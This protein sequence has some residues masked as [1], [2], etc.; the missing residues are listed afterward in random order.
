MPYK[1]PSPISPQP[2]VRCREISTADVEEVVNLL[3]R[4]FRTGRDFW[5]GAL[6]RLSDHPTP[7]GL[8]R[9][10]YL[11]ESKSIPVGVIL[12]IST[13]VPGDG[14]T[15]IQCN[16]SSWYVDPEFRVYGTVLIS[17]ALKHK[18]VTYFNVTPAPHTLPILEAQG[19]VRYC[20][21]RVVAVPALCG[22][23][24]DGGARVEAVTPAT[25]PGEDLPSSEIKLLLAHAEYGCLSLVCD[26]ASRRHP[27]V[28]A[29]RRKFGVVP[30]ALLV[31]CR[32]LEEFVRFAGPLG[33]FLARR[34]ILLV[35]V[36]ANGPIP[37]L[38]GRYSN[39]NPKYFKGPNQ[40]RLGNM[41]FSERAM[42]GA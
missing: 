18:H 24:P 1:S 6:K 33:R 25:R 32:D 31:Y 40:P 10:G 4:G 37:E 15:R 38:V 19:Y 28:F 8:P 3:A 5:L 2:R 22:Q 41:A 7:S 26:S 21:G 14:E 29:L 34:G 9:Y 23:R 42:F 20:N 11:L 35:I 12:L 17:R 36:D 30:F 16:V 39:R 27:F 13:A